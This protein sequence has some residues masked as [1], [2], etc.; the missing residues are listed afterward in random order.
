MDARPSWAENILTAREKEPGE[1]EFVT[2]AREDDEALLRAKRHTV[3][4][5]W[6][7]FLTALMVC[8]IMALFVITLNYILP[9]RWCWL[10][11]ERLHVLTSVYL[12]GLIG[13][14]LRKVDKVL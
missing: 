14:M 7:F 1:Q 9:E 5:V 10:E 8:G 11:E 13:Y 12:A 4:W 2:R 3:H 6:V